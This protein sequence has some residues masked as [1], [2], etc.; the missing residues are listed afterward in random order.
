[1]WWKRWFDAV[2]T[3]TGLLFVSWILALIALS[4]LLLDGRP[5]LFRQQRIGKD[6]RP[7]DVIK[8]RTMRDGRITR[9]GN[10][11]RQ[12]GLDET[13]QVINILRGEMSIVGPR[14]LTPDDIE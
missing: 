4:I 3:I 12:T 9:V 8:F 5:I 7:F 6:K 14:P 11:L 10:L 13:A 2:I 1:M